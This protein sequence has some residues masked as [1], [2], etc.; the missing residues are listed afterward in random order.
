MRGLPWIIGGGVVAYALTRTPG[1]SPIARAPLAAA[2]AW[3]G[4]LAGALAAWP[5]PRWNGRAAVISDGF[6]SPRP[7]G[8]Q[9][10]GVDL[11]FARIASDAYRVGSPN[12]AARITSWRTGWSRSCIRRRRVV[13]DANAARVRG[14]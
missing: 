5:V 10:R 11:M 14:S 13:R 4:P 1:A 7:G 3:S 6:G 2:P 9:H 8:V 12:G